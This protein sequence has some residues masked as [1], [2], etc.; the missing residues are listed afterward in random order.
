MYNEKRIGAHEISLDD[1]LSGFKLHL[2]DKFKVAVE[3]L[4]KKGVLVKKPKPGLM[5]Y[6]SVPSFYD[7]NVAHFCKLI[8]EN[9]NL[10]E[11]LYDNDLEF[12]NR[13]S[14]V[15]M[16]KLRDMYQRNKHKCLHDFSL[17]PSDSTVNGISGVVA[18]LHFICPV[19]K[20]IF[21]IEFEIDDPCKL[22]KDSRSVLCS[23]GNYHWCSSSAKLS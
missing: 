8:R 20:H 3:S 13:V 14:D 15:I 12:E 23:C 9:R 11:A 19:D 16:T 10:H 2:I 17:K 6:Q 18:T 21:T 7:R 5:I 22:F 4:E 1:L